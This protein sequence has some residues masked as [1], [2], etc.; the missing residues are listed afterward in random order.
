MNAVTLVEIAALLASHGKTIG[1][2]RKGLP[3]AALNAYWIAN[4]Q[5]ADQWHEALFVYRHELEKAGAS[6]RVAIWAQL[7]RVIAEILLSD[8]LSRTL[9]AIGAELER[10][11]IDEDTSP[12]TSSV[13]NTQSEARQRSLQLM[14]DGPGQ[15]L[16]DAAQ[17][18]RLRFFLDEWTDMLLAQLGDCHGSR[19][20]CHRMGRMQEWVGEFDHATESDMVG[21]DL[22]LRILGMRRWLA[23]TSLLG[24]ANPN[25]NQTIGQSV[26]A[27]LRPEWFDS[28][29]CM[30]SLAAHRMQSI[31]AET[32]GMVG[33]LLSSHTPP[34]HYLK[35]HENLARLRKSDSSNPFNR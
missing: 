31:I 15:P 27:M 5:R 32:D 17:L 2:V 7:K 33:S 20:Y 29:G 22:Q 4:R 18:N 23:K 19:L 28:L 6:K 12:I 8:V 35:T 14:F 13:A 21:I 25:F 3:L 24:D 26:L 1:Y 30:R 11:N 16:S 10:D 34:A 9:A